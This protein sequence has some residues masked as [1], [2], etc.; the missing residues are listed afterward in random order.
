MSQLR[1]L[2]YDR[3]ATMVVAFAAKGAD[4]MRACE[5]EADA[6][7]S[8]LDYYLPGRESQK[9]SMRIRMAREA[10]DNWQRVFGDLDDPKVQAE[11]DAAAAGLLATRQRPAVAGR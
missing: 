3:A 8:L 7:E 1:R 2:L 5:I 11:I 4:L 9:E 10:K 6:F